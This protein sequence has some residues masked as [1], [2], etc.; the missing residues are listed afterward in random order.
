M[1]DKPNIRVEISSHTDSRGS[2]DVN[3]TLSQARAESVVNY[4]ESKG[5]T[6]SRLLANGYG[7]DRPINRCTNGV[8]CSETEHQENRRVEFRVL[9]N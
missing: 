7:E 8:P 9:S 5:I 3:K 2:S 1:K 6:K 4:L